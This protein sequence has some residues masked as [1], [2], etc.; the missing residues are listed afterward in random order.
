MIFFFLNSI[1]RICLSIFSVILGIFLS[2]FKK[3]KK[4]LTKKV[5]NQSRLMSRYWFLSIN[6]AFSLSLALA[7]SVVL[8]LNSD[9]MHQRKEAR[10]GRHDNNF[11]NS[12]RRFLPLSP[13]S[14]MDLEGA[15][16]V[17]TTVEAAE[18]ASAAVAAACCSLLPLLSSFLSII[19]FALFQTLKGAPLF[20]ITRKLFS[21]SLT[22]ELVIVL[23]QLDFCILW[24]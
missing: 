2:D 6:D 10:N 11:V 7:R 15:A 8:E 17:E 23:F 24:R 16:A 14:T 12:L 20:I 4:V 3:E 22:F 5:P 18:G 9:E 19:F 21:L 13:F 1:A